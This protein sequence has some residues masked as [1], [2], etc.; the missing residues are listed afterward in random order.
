MS[1]QLIYNH[2][3]RQR[4]Q[5][6]QSGVLLK[7]QNIPGWLTDIV[8]LSCRVIGRTDSPLRYTYRVVTVETGEY[9][10]LSC[11]QGSGIHNLIL[12]P[13]EVTKLRRNAN[14]PTPAGIMLALSANNFWAADVQTP[15]LHC[16]EPRLPASALPEAEFQPTWKELTGHKN[17]ARAFLSTPFNK[18]CLIV[19][20]SNINGLK[21][22]QLLHESDWLSSHRGWGRTFTTMAQMGDSFEE[23]S[24]ICIPEHMLGSAEGSIWSH[25][26]PTLDL[27]SPFVLETLQK[28]QESIDAVTQ[29]TGPQTGAGEHAHTPYVYQECPDEEMYN[30]LPRSHPLLRWTCYICGLLLLGA[31]VHVMVSET[32][33]DAAKVTRKAIEVI[34]ADESI[35]QLKELS[36]APYSPDSITRTLDKIY[37]HLNAAPESEQ[38]PDKE[39]LLEIIAL[40]KYA[41]SDTT[42][43]ADNI[44]RLRECAT[45]LSLNPD[46]L[47][48]LY[49]NEAI[50][51]T[52]VQDWESN[53]TPAEIERWHHL[54]QTAP[55]LRPVMQEARFAPYMK[56]VLQEPLP[57]ETIRQPEQTQVDT[58]MKAL[59]SLACIEG[60]PLPKPLAK[61]LEK[62]PVLLYKGH[63]S[64]IRRY[65]ES[66][67]RTRFS[68]QLDGVENILRIEQVAKDRYLIVP[69]IAKSGDLVPV[70]QFDVADGKLQNLQCTSGV[71]AAA[72]IPLMSSDTT[73]TPIMLLPRREVRLTPSEVVAPPS[74]EQLHWALAEKDVVVQ[75]GEHRHL[76]IRPNKGYPWT[77]MLSAIPLQQGQ[78]V[79]QLPIIAGTNKLSTAAQAQGMQDYAWSYSKIPTSNTATD[80]FDCHLLRIYDFSP[81]LHQR[82][83]HLANTYCMGSKSGE[84]DFYSLASLYTLCLDA[85]QAEGI[86]DAATN[87]LRLLAHADFA[88]LVDSLLVHEPELNGRL[89]NLDEQG[90]HK[91][92]ADAQA[93]LSIRQCVLARLSEEIKLAYEECREQELQRA[94]DMSPMQL[95]LQQVYV[96][97]H[98]ELVWQFLLCKTE[99]P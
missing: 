26:A 46:R 52:S 66:M 2:Q 43:H 41:D 20:P 34:Q 28:I 49:L 83:H 9:H 32:T 5:G 59:P 37:A 44:L 61:A 67:T 13:D 25:Q 92:L 71:P 88:T 68:G 14:R 76:S 51:Q 72:C 21:V 3:L 53:L 1:F 70:L 38:A 65:A 11:A 56:R 12:T 84:D 47:S 93:R 55:T 19:I 86:A 89:H 73:Y 42:G 17:N 15:S 18:D 4:R 79:L 97:E 94:S 16:E 95:S 90:A 36:K 22:L 87:L 50:H 99:Q 33:D 80:L 77:R 54:L 96:S 6:D 60:D 82:F 81:N 98:G 64:I 24:R 10:I 63:W 8:L 69:Q 62:P 30:V 74:T 35:L 40:L 7:S 29:K 31:I 27:C 75:Q 91:L 39:K 78:A 48:R 58:P 57:Q 23:T 85:E 45:D